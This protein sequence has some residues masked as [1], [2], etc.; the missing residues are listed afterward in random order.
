MPCL[1]SK[2]GGKAR[3][4]ALYTGGA[5]PSPPGNPR[6]ATSSLEPSPPSLASRFVARGIAK[7]VIRG[8]FKGNT[9]A[10]EGREKFSRFVFC[11]EYHFATTTRDQSKPTRA[12]AL[13]VSGVNT[14]L[15]PQRNKANQGLNRTDYTVEGSPPLR[16]AGLLS[17][18]LLAS[19]VWGHHLIPAS[20]S[21]ADA[22]DKATD[23]GGHR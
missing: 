19:S 16:S 23:G 5:W 9:V 21:V 12:K 1:F 22:P 20:P 18:I 13:A 11:R 8:G 14:P 17:G 4:G 7:P 10:F 3:S 6:G 2:V 15:Q